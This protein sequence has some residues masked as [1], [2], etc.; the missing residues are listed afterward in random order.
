MSKN[1]K[2]EKSVEAHIGACICVRWSYDGSMIATSGEDGLVKLWSKSGMLRSTL[3]QNSN[4]SYN[5]D[6]SRAE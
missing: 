4:N 6:S 1:G 3:A 2:I 5:F